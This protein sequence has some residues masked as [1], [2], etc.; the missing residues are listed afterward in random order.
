MSYVPRVQAIQNQLNAVAAE[1]VVA[2]ENYEN[3]RV[4]FETA[5]EKFASIKN[6]AV[7]MLT[8]YDWAQWQA[9]NQDVRYAA[10]AVGD[11]ILD[12]LR[13][14]ASQAAAYH[15]EAPAYR[16]FDPFMAL[17]AIASDLERGGFEFRT[18][19]TGREVNAALINLAGVKK[20]PDGR[21]ATTDADLILGI[22][23]DIQQRGE[24]S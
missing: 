2:K 12:C 23:K 9:Q 20:S 13:S 15:L 6:L 19:A 5:R 7:Q 3:A 4:H 22:I 16:P 1:Y 11:A 18:T 10:M 14:Y 8:T 24:E 17:D 21:Y